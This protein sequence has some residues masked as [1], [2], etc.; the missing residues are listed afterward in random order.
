M[1]VYVQ[2]C[3]YTNTDLFVYKQLWILT[4]TKFIKMM[5]IYVFVY[6]QFL[7]CIRDFWF[8]YKHKYV[9]IQTC[10]L[11][12]YQQCCS[13]TNKFAFVYKRINVCIREKLFLYERAYTWIK[14]RIRT[15]LIV[16]IQTRT[17]F[18]YKPLLVCIR[19]IVVCIQT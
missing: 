8:V 9:R 19:T 15:I 2:N 5:K 12:V 11:F 6:E 1:F 14:T 18:V 10:K 13:Y 4:R 17:L 16:C 3:S 7:G